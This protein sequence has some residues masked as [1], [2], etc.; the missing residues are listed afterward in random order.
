MEMEF[1]IIQM[2]NRRDWYR[3]IWNG[4]TKDIYHFPELLNLF[5][6]FS[7]FKSIIFFWGNDERSVYCPCLMRKVDHIPKISDM[8]GGNYWD[9]IS[10]WYYGGPILKGEIS[11]EDIKHL[12]D[13]IEEYCLDNKIISLT[14]KMN[15]TISY[16]PELIEKL[17]LKEH[18]TTLILDD[19]E[20]LNIDE[21]SDDPSKLSGD[22][23]A[24]RLLELDIVEDFCHFRHFFEV[25]SEYHDDI[26][27]FQF[28]KV[29]LVLIRKLM[30]SFK[31]YIHLFT[32]I[33]KGKV[34]GGTIFLRNEDTLYYLFGSWS[35]NI[36]SENV[37][38]NFI[39]QLIKWSKE[40]GIKEIIIGGDNKENGLFNC[41]ENF[42]EQARKQ[43]FLKRIFL[44][45]KYEKA[46]R[47]TFD[48]DLQYEN[49]EF[50]PEYRAP[51]HQMKKIS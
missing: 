4:G 40:K 21:L 18:G 44:K 17:K 43:L 38:I 39:Q 28:N 37:N 35:L 19:L 33:S 32:L 14:Y 31:D 1:K 3:L 16:E 13:E 20:K 22:D 2:K 46:C 48:G 27:E 24:E 41:I 11:S 9:I 36:R 30:A 15:P 26:D 6:E 50:F 8:L 29:T 12:C 47:L 49:G 42:P 25:M 5:N 10:P 23:P 51:H 34:L 45:E 7:D